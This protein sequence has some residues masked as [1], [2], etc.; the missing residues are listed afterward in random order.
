MEN[1]LKKVIRI[2]DFGQC[3]CLRGN[4]LNSIYDENSTIH[5]YMPSNIELKTVKLALKKNKNVMAE[6]K[7]ENVYPEVVKFLVDDD[8]TRKPI[9]KIGS[10]FEVIL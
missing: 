10:I 1:E 8:S 6:I 7:H 3:S 4:D 5:V 9:S 2:L